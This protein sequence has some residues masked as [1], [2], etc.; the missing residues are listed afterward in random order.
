MSNFNSVLKQKS[1]VFHE[2]SILDKDNNHL[3]DLRI[4]QDELN[5]VMTFLNNVVLL[6]KNNMDFDLE[7]KVNQNYNKHLNSLIEG[8]MLVENNN[9]LEIKE[10]SVFI[11]GPHFLIEQLFQLA[12]NIYQSNLNNTSKFKI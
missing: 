3:I 12:K 6:S 1:I 4:S 9:N 2:Y 11:A 5:A 7:I 8:T 10:K